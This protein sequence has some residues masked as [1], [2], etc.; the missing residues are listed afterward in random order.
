MYYEIRCNS[1]PEIHQRSDGSKVLVGHAALFFNP[2]DRGTEFALADGVVERIARSA[3]DRSLASKDDVIA[4][5]DHRDAKLLG[6][7]ASGTLRLS[8]D[9]RGLEYQVPLPD[10]QLGRDVE[11]KIKRGELRGSSFRFAEPKVRWSQAGNI[12]VRELLSLTLR[13]VSVVTN[14]AYTGT[15]VRLVSKSELNRIEADRVYVA[16]AMA[17][18]RA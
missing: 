13:D 6:R 4:N 10:T 7:R 18:F 5:V 9:S 17:G 15:T 3:F 11:S 12:K 14:P 2:R 8:K 16:M 1:I